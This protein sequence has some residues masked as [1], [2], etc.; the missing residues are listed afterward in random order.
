MYTNVKGFENVVFVDFVQR[1]R[2][3]IEN[4][5]QLMRALAMAE[6]RAANFKKKYGIGP[7]E[8]G[9]K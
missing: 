9:D 7:N 8:Q 1:G 5:A 6:E 2:F 3:L 4:K